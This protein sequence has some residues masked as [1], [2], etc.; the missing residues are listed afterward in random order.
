VAQ[1]A[2]SAAHGIL[3]AALARHIGNLLEEQNDR[4][5]TN[6]RPVTEAGILTP[7]DPDHNF[8]VVDLAATCEDHDPDEPF[9][10]RPFL[11]VEIL[12]PREEPTQRAKLQMFSA[13]PGVREILFLDSRI[14]RAEL[15]R[16]RPDGGWPRSPLISERDDILEWET[17]GLR[18]PLSRLYRG[19]YPG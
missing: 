8:R 12:S 15:H 1:A 14:P 16:R 11:L 5:G 2:P 13:L 10:R 3:Q 19:L 4:E 7:L 17:V 9:V 6:C 18:L